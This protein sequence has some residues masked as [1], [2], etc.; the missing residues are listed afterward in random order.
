M[1][2]QNKINNPLIPIIMKSNTTTMRIHKEKYW[3]VQQS[4]DGNFND[5]DEIFQVDRKY[6]NTAVWEMAEMIYPE[7]KTH[8]GFYNIEEKTR[9]VLK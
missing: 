6:S 5:R 2:A 8:R 7:I 3:S 1:T 9:N 4:E